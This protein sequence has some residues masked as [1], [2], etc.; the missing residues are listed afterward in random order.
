MTHYQYRIHLPETDFPKETVE[1]PPCNATRLTFG[2]CCLN[3]GY[4]PAI[5]GKIELRSSHEK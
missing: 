4:D 3:C 2:D 1:R 5:H